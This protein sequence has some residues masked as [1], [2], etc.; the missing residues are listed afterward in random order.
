M[1]SLPAESSWR[2][3]AGDHNG[4]SAYVSFNLISRGDVQGTPLVE[5]T[6]DDLLR[7]VVNGLR[8]NF[9]TARAAGCA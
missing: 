5:M 2:C 4:F 1:L 3:A 8:S 6:A 7:A 9:L